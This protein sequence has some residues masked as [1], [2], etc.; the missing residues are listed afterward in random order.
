MEIAISQHLARPGRP[1]TNPDNLCAS[2][3]L[4]RT[5]YGL[6]ALYKLLCK[7]RLPRLEALVPSRAELTVPRTRSQHRTADGHHLQLSCSLTSRASK[8]SRRSFP[9]FLIQPWNSLPQSILTTKP[10]L[11]HLQ[12][13]KTGAY[14][15][16]RARWIGIGLPRFIHR[17]IIISVFSCFQI[18]IL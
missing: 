9:Y 12:A 3:L 11:K 6:C 18:F 2:C 15:H 17:I 13:F 8:T 7:P 14:K 10:H 4:R 5:I 1:V 16:L